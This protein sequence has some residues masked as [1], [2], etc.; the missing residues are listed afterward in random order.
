M[1]QLTKAPWIWFVQKSWYYC[2]GWADVRYDDR[3]SCDPAAIALSIIVPYTNSQVRAFLSFALAQTILFSRVHHASS[4]QSKCWPFHIYDAIISGGQQRADYINTCLTCQALI[5]WKSRLLILRSYWQPIVLLAPTPS[6]W[7]NNNVAT[8]W[9]Q[10]PWYAL[11]AKHRKVERINSRLVTFPHYET[12]Q[13]ATLITLN[14]CT[15]RSLSPS[16]M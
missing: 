2:L 1:T 3:W 4:T 6:D 9:F 16:Y 11:T 7:L 12:D 10:N 14:C 13:G 8:F 15:V 5:D